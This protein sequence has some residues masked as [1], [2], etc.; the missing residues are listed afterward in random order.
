[1]KALVMYDKKRGALELKE[2]QKPDINKND[3]LVRV[4]AAAI[5]GSDIHF[6]QGKNSELLNTP[7]VLGHEF[8]GI[9]AEK[10]EDVTY[11]KEGDRV[12]SDNTGYVCGKCSFCLTGRFVLCE[13]RKG[14]GYGMDGGFAEYVKIPG[15]ILQK[16]SGCLLRLSE[17]ISFEEASIIEPSCNAY[18]ALIQDAHFFPGETIIIFGPGAI[19]LFCVQFA[20]IAGASRIIIVGTAGDENRLDVAKQLGADHTIIADNNVVERVLDCNK[21]SY[22][23]IAIDA[24]GPPIIMEHAL[25]VIKREGQII[26]IGMSSLPFKTSLD[27]LV[28]K[29]VV[30]KGHFGYDYI[31]WENVLRL[32]EEGKLQYKPLISEVLPIEKWKEGFEKVKAKE[33]IKIVLKP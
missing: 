10:G 5:C 9:I 15:D 31:S 11:W 7:V 13:E 16:F 3:I 19:G 1:M 27:L 2:I 6:W 4:K 23:D 20:K 18:R 8:S 17:N 24:A 12:V 28:M 14:L 21:N 33:A 22:F 25:R 30:V 26:K 29:A 32:I